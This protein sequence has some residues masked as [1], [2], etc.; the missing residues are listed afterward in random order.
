MGKE[1]FT[2]PNFDR[3]TVPGHV[4]PRQGETVG[5]PRDGRRRGGSVAADARHC[6]PGSR[7]DQPCP[8]DH[9]QGERR[10]ED[11][12][13]Q[14]ALPR[15]EVRRREAREGGGARP[16]RCAR[17]VRVR[18][19]QLETRRTA[20]AGLGRHQRHDDPAAARQPRR[21]VRRSHPHKA[22]LLR[23]SARELR[24]RHRAGAGRRAAADRGHD[25]RRQ[26]DRRPALRLGR[27]PRLLVLARLRLLR[28]GQLRPRRRRLPLQPADIGRSWSPGARP[29]RGAGSRST[30]APPTP[31]P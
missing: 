3:A 25:Q 17:A 30:R 14:P 29:G 20:A 4:R 13:R 9:S 18:R 2:C 11:D 1:S 16:C 6:G 21:T 23:R 19:E 8:D 22:E 24:Q 27:G 7:R 10:A 5:R 28:R 26:H 15:H 31:T 12:R